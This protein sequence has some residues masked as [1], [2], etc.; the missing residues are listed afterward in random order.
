MELMADLFSAMRENG[1][2]ISPVC[3]MHLKIETPKTLTLNVEISKFLDTSLIDA[4]MHPDWVTIK[5]KDK[6]LQLN[7]NATVSPDKSICER[8]KLSGLLSIIMM[9]VGV[10][11]DGNL[12]I[13]RLQERKELENM[14]R[15]EEEDKK[16]VLLAKQ[17]RNRRY[18]NLFTPSEAV[19]YKNIVSSKNVN[20]NV[21]KT[22]QISVKNQISQATLLDEDFVDDP[23]V[24]PLC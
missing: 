1:H 9:K 17:N 7:L 8:S 22:K 16:N 19:D 5:I 14:K 12:E 3:I 20:E 23:S 15:K 18:E 11:K 21:T 6:I 10:E 4:D 24:P 13:I 2:F